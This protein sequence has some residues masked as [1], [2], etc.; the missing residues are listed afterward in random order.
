VPNAKPQFAMRSLSIHTVI[1]PSATIV[2]ASQ[3]APRARTEKALGEEVLSCF[4][5]GVERGEV[6]A[7][8]KQAKQG[9]EVGRALAAGSS[10]SIPG[11]NDMGAAFAK[12]WAHMASWRLQPGRQA[13]QSRME[14]E[15]VHPDQCKFW[16]CWS[17]QLHLH[18]FWR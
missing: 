18:L 11:Y 8:G 7:A 13:Q 2:C 16:R 1:P 4:N 15:M 3:A 10:E 12:V 9:P 6:G 17:I 14:W 5:S